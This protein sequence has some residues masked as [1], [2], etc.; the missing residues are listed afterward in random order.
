MGKQ[1]RIR[2]NTTQMRRNLTRVT[3][4][5]PSDQLTKFAEHDT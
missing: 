1:A 4:Q 5:Q 2:G 3:G